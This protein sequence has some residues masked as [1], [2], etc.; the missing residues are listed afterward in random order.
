MSF[1]ICFEDFATVASNGRHFH[2]SKMISHVSF[3]IWVPKIVIKSLFIPSK[4][5]I[6]KI[7]HLIRLRFE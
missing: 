6:T 5:T 3:M 7:H 1:K 4:L 2:F